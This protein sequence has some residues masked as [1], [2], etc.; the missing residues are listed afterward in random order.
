VRRYSKLRTFSEE[1]L[2][3]WRLIIAASRLSEEI[4]KE[5]AQLMAI[6]QKNF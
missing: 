6:I 4:A 3:Q 1:E 5:E 2:E